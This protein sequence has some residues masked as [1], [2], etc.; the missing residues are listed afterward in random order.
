MVA[1]RVSDGSIL[2]L[3][4][5]MLRAPIVE[6]TQNG[7][8]THHSNKRGTPQGGV[9]SPLLAN[10]YLNGLDHGVNDHEGAHDA[11][12]IRYAD[13]FVIATRPGKAE[14]LLA[15]L[16]TY[17]RA[18][19]LTLNEEK[20]RVAD[21]RREPIR[22]LGFSI[23]WRR[24]RQTGNAYVH[25]EPSVKAQEHYK[26]AVRE[27]LNHWTQW[28]SC[29]EAVRQVNRISQGWAN[30]YHYANSTRVFGKMQ[31]WLENRLRTWLWHKYDWVRGK[32]KFFTRE[33]LQG[34]YGLWEMP[35]KAAWKPA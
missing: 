33:R 18:R 32:Y 34:Q 16:K 14:T 2:S 11:K 10:L 5:A 22:F 27:K 31:N 20:T 17:L 8:T 25:V 6:Q 30:Y 24:S 3:V 23:S 4:K 12:L 28:G 19:K 35:L 15:R 9:L 29:A 1:R 26:R 7:K 21:T 13:D